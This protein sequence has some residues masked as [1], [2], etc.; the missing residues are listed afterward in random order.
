[1]ADLTI[2]AANVVKGQNASIDRTRN[3]GEALT[4]GQAVYIKS[5]DDKYWKAQADGTAEEATVAGVALHAAA[6]NQP[7]AVQTG[8]E[9][10]IGA[11]VVV[12]T[13]YVVSAAAGGIAPWADLVSTNKVSILGHG[14]TAAL[15]VINPTVTGVAIP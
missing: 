1:M 8:G 12:G 2:T 11:T 10:T 4:A 9:I 14:K 3:A 5:S 6:A 13:I 15:L 7:I